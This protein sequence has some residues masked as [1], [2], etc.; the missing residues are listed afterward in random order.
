[1]GARDGQQGCVCCPPDREPDLQPQRVSDGAGGAGMGVH[2]GHRPASQRAAGGAEAD[3][4]RPTRSP[5]S[6]WGLPA[7]PGP[8]MLTLCG[9]ASLVTLTLLGWLAVGPGWSKAPALSRQTR[10][11]GTPNRNQWKLPT[12][13][14]VRLASSSPFPH[15]FSCL[16]L[17]IREFCP[18][19]GW[20]NV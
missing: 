5:G 11:K 17:F 20:R 12:R 14:K 3:G 19:L 15:L 2:G 1:M 8:Q 13:E 6:V 4:Q 9:W 7:P 10:G 16:S 18:H